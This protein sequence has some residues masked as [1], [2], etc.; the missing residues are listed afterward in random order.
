MLYC[1]SRSANERSAMRLWTNTEDMSSKPP[2][3]LGAPSQPPA[4]L[5]E[6]IDPEV[7]PKGFVILCVIR[8]PGIRIGISAPLAGRL[9]F[10]FCSS[11]KKTSKRM[12]CRYSFFVH[13]IYCLCTSFLSSYSR[14]SDPGSHSRLFSPP[15]GHPYLGNI[16]I[17]L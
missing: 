15:D 10:R 4:V 5:L 7:H 12:R 6:K 16:T 8:V 11:F 3:S 17:M 2:F 14:N 9:C 1:K 13:P